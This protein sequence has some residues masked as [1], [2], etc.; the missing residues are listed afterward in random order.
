MII[1][2][3]W[4]LAI[5]SMVP[6]PAH[7]PMRG[8]LVEEVALF[9]VSWCVSA[10]Q[11]PLSPPSRLLTAPRFCRVPILVFDSECDSVRR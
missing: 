8:C 9:K 6:F 4:P 10:L 5:R 3:S 2:I 7:W 1:L 11:S